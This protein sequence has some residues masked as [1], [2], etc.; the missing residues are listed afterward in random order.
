[1][2]VYPSIRLEKFGSLWTDIN[3]IWYLSIFLKSAKKI[4]VSL[5]SDNDNGYFVWRTL[6]A[7]D[8]ISLSFS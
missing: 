5:Q 3:E 1:M 6:D 2:Y 8:H 7:F 4:K